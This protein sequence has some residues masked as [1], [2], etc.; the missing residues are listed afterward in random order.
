MHKLTQ[1]LFNVFA[2]NVQI[3]KIFLRWHTKRYLSNDHWLNAS[4]LLTF[5]CVP[6]LWWSFVAISICFN[7]SLSLSLSFFID[8]IEGKKKTWFKRTMWKK[9]LLSL[10]FCVMNIE[11]PFLS[12]K[13]TVHNC[14]YDKSIIFFRWKI[15]QIRLSNGR[16]QNKINYQN[17]YHPFDNQMEI[18]NILR[19]HVKWIND[20]WTLH[21]KQPN[22]LNIK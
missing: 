3:N 14:S 1:C 7:L 9:C 19:A 22:W 12:L 10:V 8:F 2:W 13:I 15:H 17:T 11:N 5:N 6:G 20:V 18:S 4:I 16:A 21:H